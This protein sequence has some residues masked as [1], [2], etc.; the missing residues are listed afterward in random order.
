MEN[1]EKQLLSAI[2]SDLLTGNYLLGRKRSDEHK[3][4]MKEFCI[5]SYNVNNNKELT[6]REKDMMIEMGK[7]FYEGI[8]DMCE[9][10]NIDYNNLKKLLN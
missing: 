7:I 6:N 5:T 8:P 9:Q 2:A 3:A 1:K 10:L 4:L